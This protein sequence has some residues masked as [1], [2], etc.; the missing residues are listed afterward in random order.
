MFA[1]LLYTRMTSE[2]R[3]GSSIDYKVLFRNI[4]SFVVYIYV[5]DMHFKDARLIFNSAFKSQIRD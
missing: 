1:S 3:L 4:A 2:E 5:F